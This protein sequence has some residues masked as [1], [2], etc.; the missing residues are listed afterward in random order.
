[1]L[2][3][4]TLG[5]LWIAELIDRSNFDEWQ[6]QGKTSLLDRARHKIREILKSHKPEPLNTDVQKYLAEL[7]QKD[8]SK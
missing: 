3:S 1:M 4:S 7:A 8:N 2:P 6:A 5:V